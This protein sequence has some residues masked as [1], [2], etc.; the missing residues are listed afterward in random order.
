MAVAGITGFTMGCTMCIFGF[1]WS[2]FG[3]VAEDTVN[4]PVMAF[5]ISSNGFL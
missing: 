4:S 5:P 3:I 1:R 2:G